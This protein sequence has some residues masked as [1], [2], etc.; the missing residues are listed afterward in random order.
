MLAKADKPDD[1]R[2][3]L[4]VPGSGEALVFPSHNFNYTRKSKKSKVSCYNEL[5]IVCHVI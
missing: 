4:S 1:T 3:Q 2:D 5:N